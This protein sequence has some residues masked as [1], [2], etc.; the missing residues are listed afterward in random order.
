VAAYYR[1]SESQWQ[2][3]PDVHSTLQTLRV[4]GYRLGLIS[5]NPD[6]AHARR[7]IAAAKLESYFD[8]IVLSAEA[9]VRK[10]NPALFRRVLDAWN[11]PPEQCVVIGDNLGADILGAQLT[12]LRHVWVTQYADHAA[13]RAHQGNIVPEAE[14]AS[15]ADLPGL[16]ERW[17]DSPRRPEDPKRHEGEKL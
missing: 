3:V 1:F 16:L 14:I 6:A 17:R 2:P 5:N 10:P 15:L 4:A 13:N 12:G 9:G 7:L 11:Q 8:P